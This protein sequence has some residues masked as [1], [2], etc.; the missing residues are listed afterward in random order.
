MRLT[1]FHI[2]AQLDT[3]DLQRKPTDVLSQGYGIQI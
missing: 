1:I 3:L 2:S